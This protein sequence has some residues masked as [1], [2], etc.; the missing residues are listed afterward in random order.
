MDASVEP[1]QPDIM[2]IAVRLADEGVPVR[3]IARAT[4]TPSGDIYEILREALASGSIV[5][6]PKD[7]WPPGSQRASR[8]AFNGTPYESDEVLKLGCARVFKATK[9]EAAFLS[10]M[11][12]RN[13]V[14]KAQLHIVIE[15]CRASEH[16][17]ETDVKMVDVI[18]CKLRKKLTP[19]N[20]TIETVWGIGYLIPVAARERAMTM[21]FNHQQDANV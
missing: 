14:T 7:D 9:L 4:R 12:K 6:I 8:T 10:V 11:L 5:E 18:I 2:P 21:L 17:D 19:H 1:A 3:A 15:Q 16:R 13:E 20:I